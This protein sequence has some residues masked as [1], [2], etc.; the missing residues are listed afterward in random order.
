MKDGDCLQIL[1]SLIFLLTGQFLVLLAHGEVHYYDFVMKETNVTKLCVNRTILTVNDN[2]PG[3]VIRI[4]KGDTVFVNVH[5]QGYYG[6]TIHWHGV[7]QP[8]NPW[9]DGPEYITQCPIEP[10]SNFT[11]QV[12]FSDEEGTLWWH[13]HSD[14]T[15]S[16]VHGAIVILPKEGTSYPFHTP[17]GD[18][19]L[20]LSA[21]YKV[22]DLYDE[23]DEAIKSASDLPH[24]SG[25]AIN[26]ELGDFSNC[27]SETTNHYTVEYGKTYLLRIVN[28]VVNA[29]LF[30][31]IA[32]HNL[33]AVGMDGAYI[34]PIN[35]TYIMV[36]PGQT[37]DVLFTANQSPG[38]YY[39]A[40]RQFS[41]EN[42]SVTGFDHS[43]GSAIVEYSGGEY[44]SSSSSVNYPH[45]LPQNLDMKSGREFVNRIRS[46]DSED[47]PT[48]IPTNITTR[49]YITVSMNVLCK[50]STSCSEQA[51]GNML[52][53]SLNN[54]SWVN[55][56]MDVLQAYYR[57]I[58][59]IYTEDFPDFPS[60]M[61]NFT[62]DYDD[63]DLNLV[64]T[65]QATKV[66]VLEY[67]E[68][69]EIVFQ[70]TTL[71]QGSVNHPMHLHGHSFYVVGLGYGNFN[72][73]TDPQ[74]YNLVDPPKINTFGVPKSGWLTIRFTANN[75]GVWFW[76]CHLD[77]H[78]TWGMNTAF[79][80]KNGG[81][82]E[83]TLRPPPSYMPTC[84]GSSAT[85]H[86][87]TRNSVDDEGKDKSL[88]SLPLYG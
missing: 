1:K 59:G 35:S 2:F 37:I 50:N 44:N 56:E 78:M 46:L 85:G 15:R 39:M 55:P 8:G 40:V 4:H 28:A 33:T 36:S 16:T 25:Y 52:A 68:S 75:P 18:E 79:I 21:W 31:A 63:Y 49:M 72:N 74:T 65:N 29:E 6:V 71:L 26:G 61:Y 48:S 13:A 82:K 66:K 86:I 22:G 14:W 69:V 10:G 80:V 12:I 27:S 17:D 19:V 7:K 38:N 30:F 77:R 53:T 42:P 64:V 5:N 43:L 23:L 76:H 67:G 84:T 34:K 60:I 3:P 87:R 57:N 32:D 81:T 73:E 83:S 70:G 24:S 88:H 41:S 47:Y 45:N 62:S 51:M 9:S 11:Y 20:V 54:I 58:S